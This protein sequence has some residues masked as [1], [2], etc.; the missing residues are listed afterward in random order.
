MQYVYLFIHS[1]PFFLSGSTLSFWLWLYGLADK[2]WPSKIP[3]K[4]NTNDNNLLTILI[5]IHNAYLMSTFRNCGLYDDYY[6]Y[7][8]YAA[9][10]D[11]E[12]WTYS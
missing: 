11:F 9:Q 10:N 8:K 12:Q 3:S 4:Q 2:S 5:L 1:F 6:Y 7:I